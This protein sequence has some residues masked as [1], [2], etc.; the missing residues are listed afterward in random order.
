MTQTP[1]T[2]SLLLGH[3]DIGDD[4]F[5]SSTLALSETTGHRGFASLFDGGSVFGLAK[6]KTSPSVVTADAAKQSSGTGNAALPVII[7]SG[8]TV[9]IDGASGQAVSFSGDTGTLKLEDA[10]AFTGKVSGLAGSDAIDLADVSYGP[11]TTATFL[12]NTSGGTLTITNGRRPRTSPCR[13]TICRHTG[14]CPAM[15]TA[16]PRWLIRH[17]QTHGKHSMSARVGSLE[18]LILRPTAPWSRAPIPTVLISG[19]APNGFSS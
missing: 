7:A 17:L 3:G 11:N 18:E 10:I 13:A 12:G 15:D 4:P 6:T 2:R 1:A 9:E 16:A 14:R 8:G 5:N 19:M